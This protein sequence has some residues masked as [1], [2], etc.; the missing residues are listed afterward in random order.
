MMKSQTHT[1]NTPINQ[2]KHTHTHTHTH[3][4]KHAH[5]HTHSHTQTAWFIFG[6]KY[7]Y[8][9]TRMLVCKITST[10]RKV[11]VVKQNKIK[12]ENE[13]KPV[14]YN[15][16]MC[17]CNSLGERGRFNKT[18]LIRGENPG[19]NVTT[20]SISGPPNHMLIDFP[21][22]DTSREITAIRLCL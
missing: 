5:M 3:S 2:H 12:S 9:T 7:N 10:N 15:M 6:M 21:A 11:M 1:Q 18:V 4:H 14:I 8:C 16:G 13:R 22:E 20:N 19:E 17:W